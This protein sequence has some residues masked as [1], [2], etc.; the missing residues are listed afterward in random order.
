M[1]ITES[2]LRQLIRESILLTEAVTVDE[3]E[4]TAKKSI[5]KAAKGK[6]WE[7][8]KDG[9]LVD[10]DEE[11][12][13]WLKEH[14]PQFIAIAVMKKSIHF[15]IGSKYNNDLPEDRVGDAV[16]WTHNQLFEKMK[17]DPTHLSSRLEKAINAVIPFAK[18]PNEKRIVLN[19]EF[20]PIINEILDS[21]FF[22]RKNIHHLRNFK[23]TI[24]NYYQMLR[25][26]EPAEKRDIHRVGDIKELAALVIDATPRY[27]DHDAK[28]KNDPE[29]IS[30][31]T[32]ILLDDDSW[33]IGAIHNCEA[34]HY[35]AKCSGPERRLTLW[36]TAAPGV[37]CDFFKKYYRDDDPLIIFKDKRNQ[38]GYQF[39]FSSRQFMDV[40][41][42]FV[43]NEKKAELTGLLASVEHGIKPSYVYIH[44]AIS[45]VWP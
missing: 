34:A 32:E 10:L 18:R 33:W 20:H 40:G 37:G 44:N 30:N 35:H 19:W 24:E 13:S 25:F 4:A 36:C 15:A 21:W 14:A 9:K 43:G 42:K 11:Q 27:Q 28:R 8:E 41:D 3:A 5:S 45:G 6:L 26:I 17:D 38:T 16:K 31:G 2:K 12:I 23:P 1:R 22:V 7:M 39:S 29:S